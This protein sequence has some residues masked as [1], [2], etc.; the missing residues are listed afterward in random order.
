MTMHDM[1]HIMALALIATVVGCF[2]SNFALAEPENAPSVAPSAPAA[3]TDTAPGP[4]HETIYGTVSKIDGEI[5]TVQQPAANDYVANGVK[6]N[7]V[8][9]YVGKETKKIG[10]E[11]KVGDK[12]RAEVTRGRGEVVAH[13]TGWRR[14]RPPQGFRAAQ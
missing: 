8:R 9:V 7:E 13:G 10:G 11:K 6:A 4:A 2:G 14:I 12:I 1:K 5:Y 3:P